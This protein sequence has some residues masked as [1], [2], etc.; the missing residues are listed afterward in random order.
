MPAQEWGAPSLYQLYPFSNQKHQL[1]VTEMLV[2]VES[3]SLGEQLCLHALKY[4]E[5]EA[6]AG[7]D[8]IWDKVFTI[9]QKNQV[10]NILVYMIYWLLIIAFFTV[11]PRR[12]LKRAA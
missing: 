5:Y 12:I 9:L 6:Y 1:K 7:F 8:H 11:F 4:P 2:T 3:G 10:I